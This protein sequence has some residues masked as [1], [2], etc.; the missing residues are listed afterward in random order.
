MVDVIHCGRPGIV[1]EVTD[2]NVEI[3]VVTEYGY[4]E[5]NVLDPAESM[6]SYRL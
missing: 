3:R 6:A 4:V 1:V 2:K 5:G